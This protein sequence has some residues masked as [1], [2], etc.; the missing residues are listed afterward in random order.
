MGIFLKDISLKGKTALITGATKGLGRGTAEAIA[1]AGGNIIAIGR[2]Q[3]ELNSLGKKIKKLKV[4]Y[5]SFNCDV[6]NYDKIKNFITKLKKLDILVNNAGTNIPEN[7]LNVKKNSLETLLNVNTKAVFNIAQLCANQI[8]KLKRKQGSIINISS[9]FGLVA[10]QK[11][12]VYSMTKFGVEGLT[13]GMALDLAKYNIRVNSVC[14]NIVLTPRTKKYFSD[15]KYNKY[16]KE[17]T[18]INKVVTISD[19]ATSITFLASEASSMITGTSVIID[20][21]WTA[22]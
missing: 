14:P 22:K 11:R 8:I 1:E 9:I 20:G 15:K 12:T 17:S 19:V 10:G 6:N 7:F 13:K 18:P 21:G 3:S 16:V 4:Q 5:T 2:N